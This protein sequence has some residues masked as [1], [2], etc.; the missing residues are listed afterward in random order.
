MLDFPYRTC[1]VLLQQTRPIGDRYGVVPMVHK[2]VR[3][4]NLRI[5][6]QRAFFHSL[7]RRG[8]GS[9]AGYPPT[10]Q[11]KRTPELRK[12]LGGPSWSVDG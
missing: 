2:K 1:R 12:R 9:C 3:W 8:P 5:G 6:C 10:D 4:R 11:P 7:T